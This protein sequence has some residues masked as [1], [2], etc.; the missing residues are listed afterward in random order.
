MKGAL[1]SPGGWLL[2]LCALLTGCA[3]ASP[4]ASPPEAAPAAS[5]PVAP[6]EPV[7]G[8]PAATEVTSVPAQP[9]SAAKRPGGYYL[10]DGPL[11][12]PPPDLDL[13]PDPVPK[14]ETVRPANLRPYRAF[15]RTYVP[16]TTVGD[17]RAEGTATWYGRRYHRL[18]TASGEPYDMYALTAAHPTLPIPSYARV[19]NLKN[20]RTIV[21]RINDR[22]PF[23]DDRLI[24]LSY[25][26]AFKLGLMP[27]GSGRVAVES[28]DPATYVAA[29]PQP[30]EPVE[31]QAPAGMYLQMGAFAARAN[32]QSLADQVRTHIG[33]GDRVRLLLLEGLF[34]VLVG[35]YDDPA[36]ARLA[37][38]DIEKTLAIR[39]ILVRR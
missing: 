23:K 8:L 18:A 7:T 26:A 14:V 29:A 37:G 24:D 1:A 34:R 17:Y 27:S 13:L 4:R 20:H 5:A 9:K 19:T 28:L 31:T 38:T 21:V 25:A 22:G 35:P 11:P 6:V 39:P 3:T 33:A 32:A 36:D 16:L 10:D 2:L 30:R 12:N 15:G